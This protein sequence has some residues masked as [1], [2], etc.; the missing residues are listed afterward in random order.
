MC[1]MRL[2]VALAECLKV[3]DVIAQTRATEISEKKGIA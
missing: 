3:T 2:A 1:N